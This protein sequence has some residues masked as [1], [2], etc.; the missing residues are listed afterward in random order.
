VASPDGKG[1]PDQQSGDHYRVL[2][3]VVGPYA[4][5]GVELVP[6]LLQSRCNDGVL[7]LAICMTDRS[8]IG[9]SLETGAERDH[10][11]V[12]PRTELDA[13]T[14]SAPG[15]VARGADEFGQSL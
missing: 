10:H 15:T 13:A 4:A 14:G 3:E 1:V 11:R 7:R 6:D 2:P 12:M 9:T 8:V 5:C